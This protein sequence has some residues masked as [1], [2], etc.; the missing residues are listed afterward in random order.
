MKT[1]VITGASAGIGKA[2]VERFAKDNYRIIALGKN[3]S[4]LQE[5]KTMALQHGSLECLAFSIDLACPKSINQLISSLKSIDAIDSLVNCAGIAYTSRCDEISIKEWEEVFRVNV[6]SPFFLIQK[7]LPWMKKSKF[8]S[9]VNV[10]SIAG[11]SRSISLGCHYSASKAALIGL[12][13]HLAAELGPYKIRVNCTA[14]SQTHSK[15]LDKALSQKEQKLLAEKVPLKRLAQVSEQ[16][17]V[18]YYLCTPES[19]YINGAV[20]DVNGGLL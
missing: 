14:P 20:I 8:P 19:S 2:C 12:T 17:D 11:R 9:I 3:A 15:M 7:M 4:R 5:V 1:V 18:I 10:S 13:R 6:A 16:A